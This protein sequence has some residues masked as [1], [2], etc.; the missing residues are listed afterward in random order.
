MKATGKNM[1]TYYAA[2]VVVFSPHTLEVF[3]ANPED[4]FWLGDDEMLQDRESNDMELAVHVPERFV[5]LT[6]KTL[7]KRV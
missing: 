7:L 6:A 5:P 2:G 3:S 4:Y 1:R